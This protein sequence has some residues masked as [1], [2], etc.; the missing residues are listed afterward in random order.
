M[1]GGMAELAR[2]LA[3]HLATTDRLSLYCLPK[4]GIEGPWQ[5]AG[6]LSGRPGRDINRLRAAER[7]ESPPDLW[8]A[9]NAGLVPLAHR[10]E[11]PFFAYFHGNDFTNPWLACGP[12]L[13]EAVR[14]P[15]AS[16]IRHPLRRRAIAQALPKVRH[17]F[18]NS[19]Q[20]AKLIHQRLGQT[21][22][23]VSVVHPGVG[24]AFFQDI[25]ATATDEAIF[26][27]LEILTVTRLSSHTRRKN[28][29]GVL[30]A[31]A[32]LEADVRYTVVGDG[33]DRPRLQALAQELGLADRVTFAGKV[34]LEELLAAYRQAD[35]FILASKATADDVEGFGIVY[36]EASASGVPAMCSR[37]GGA[38]DAVVDG[39]NG[40][41]IDDSSPASIAAGIERFRAERRSFLPQKAR[42]FAEEFR[43]PK[44]ATQLR[45]GLLA[46]LP[47]PP[48]GR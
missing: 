30:R 14:R 2:G 22:S 42:D 5:L 23:R 12:G 7:S 25:E 17:L 46:H 6:E 33:D 20:T 44:I 21:S 39:V 48:S 15:Y 16:R 13:L 41:Q 38:T 36:I 9:M 11:R 29:D 10:L 28:V 24:D 31:L 1:L 4:C 32:R 45:D 47:S 3:G 34:D 26:S 40:L 18:T 37:A 8:L 43:W 27:P 19:H 35:L